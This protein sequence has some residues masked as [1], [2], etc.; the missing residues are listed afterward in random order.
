MRRSLDVRAFPCCT[1][2]VT[3]NSFILLYASCV[4]EK[5][6]QFIDIYKDG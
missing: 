3:W 1:R 5:Y 6:S 4:H 2:N